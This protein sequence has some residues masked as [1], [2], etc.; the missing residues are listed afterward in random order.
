[1]VVTSSYNSPNY[2]LVGIYIE[3]AAG[4]PWTQ[5]TTALDSQTSVTPLAILD[6]GS[7]RFDVVYS[8]HLA[9]TSVR[10]LVKPVVSGAPLGS[11]EL[12]SDYADGYIS[13]ATNAD[14]QAGVIYGKMVGGAVSAIAGSFDLGLGWKAG[15]DVAGGLPP[16]LASQAGTIGLGF[17][18]DGVAFVSWVDGSTATATPNNLRASRLVPNPM[19][20]A[21]FTAGA[22]VSL[23]SFTDD[24]Y[25]PMAVLAS[26]SGRAAVITQRAGLTFESHL[27]VESP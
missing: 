9:D 20:A 16:L 6:R 19:D 4:V 18:G 24:Q 3:P 7:N 1:L 21:D 2:D 14:G 23:A 12:A 13:A 11:V 25:L 5:L 22:V 8:A 15:H 10:L 17:A 26:R 27:F